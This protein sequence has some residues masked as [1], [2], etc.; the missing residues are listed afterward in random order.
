ML[1]KAAI[2]LC[3]FMLG[4]G[5]VTAVTSDTNATTPVGAV[6]SHVASSSAARFGL[7]AGLLAGAKT[8][9]SGSVGV[10]GFAQGSV[11]ASAHRSVATSDAATDGED[12]GGC[13]AALECGDGTDVDLT[14][15]VDVE[16]QGEVT[17]GIP[18][19]PVSCLW[20]LLGC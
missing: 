14:V 13:D 19:V 8:A 12:S 7:A 1:V 5:G 9:D 10:E 3:G 2:T 4:I 18:A 20:V 6:E 17:A 11:D 16:V 15:D